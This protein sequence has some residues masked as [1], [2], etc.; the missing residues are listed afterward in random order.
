MTVHG[1]KGL[2]FPVVMLPFLWSPAWIDE[3]RTIPVV[4]DEDRS[5]VVDVGGPG[6]EGHADHLDEHLAWTRDEEMRLAYVA[7]TRARHQVTVWWARAWTAH[8]SPLC[9]ILM[10]DHPL[11]ERAPEDAAMRAMI[12]E[13]IAGSAI[14]VSATSGAEP[15]PWRPPDESGAGLEV[16]PWSRSVD[17]TWRRH[18]FS[19]TVEGT[20]EQ[21]VTSEPDLAPAAEPGGEGPAGATGAAPSDGAALP[22]GD[23]PGGTGFGSLVHAVLEEHA[24]GVPEPEADLR[25]LL[26]H[27]G[28]RLGLAL[29]HP[30]VVAR[31]L[32]GAVAAP[33]APGLSLRDL[34][35]G[36]RSTE[37]WFE[38][39]LAGGGT[40]P[41]AVTPGA[42]AGLWR[43]HVPAGD[44]LAEYA[45][46]L[47]APGMTAV[48]RGHLT[49]AI[50]LIA[51]LPDGRFAVMDH[52]T[53]RLGPAPL[54]AAH[55]RPAALADEMVRAHYPLQALF[56]LVALHRI[57]RWRLAGYDPAQHLAGAAY[58][59]LRGM[60][61]PGRA[62]AGDPPPGVFWWRPPADLIGAVDDLLADG[63]AT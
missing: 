50:D 24:P 40:G 33:L 21:R 53:N 43:R 3:E 17:T 34:G 26:D 60:G 11:E 2:E 38:L 63:V 55:Y 59:F 4:H 49:G 47:E 57:L 44:P 29:D 37:V 15:I 18:S 12:E 28:A 61:A 23:A 9:R 31:G 58:L 51:H 1:A 13:R 30:D 16:R 27:H 48:L 7:L 45:E 8:E 42:L 52:K 39:P 19:S 62:D 14:E 32:A 10:P 36:R 25:R 5:R 6:S 22:L 41:R 35:P 20:E 56:Y 54:R 46:R